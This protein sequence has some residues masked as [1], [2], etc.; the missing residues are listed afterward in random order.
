MSENRILLSFGKC[1]IFK[2]NNL[3]Q[4]FQ[5]IYNYEIIIKFNK[6]PL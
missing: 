4:D 3:K 2:E 5:N 6:I 1:K